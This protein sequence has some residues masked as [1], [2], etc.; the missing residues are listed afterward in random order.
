MDRHVVRPLCQIELMTD[1]LSWR[2]FRWQLAFALSL[3]DEQ[4]FLIVS[5]RVTH[6]YVQFAGSADGVVRA[7]ARS[8][9]YVDNPAFVL[10]TAQYRRLQKLG[11]NRPTSAADVPVPDGDRGGPNFWID[12]EPPE[13]PTEVARL[14][15]RTLRRVYGVPAVKRLQYHAFN[16]D[17]KTLLFPHFGVLAERPDV[18]ACENESW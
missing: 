1:T 2:E 17:G 5:D 13:H 10:D 14:A 11:W 8:N 12:F 16:N 9:Q 18:R 7:E 3:L 6:H 15:T 4:E